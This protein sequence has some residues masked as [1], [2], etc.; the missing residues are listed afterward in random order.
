MAANDERYMQSDAMILERVAQ[1]RRN[2][3]LAPDPAS[4]QIWLNRI[5]SGGVERFDDARNAI[6]QRAQQDLIPELMHPGDLDFVGS[7]ESILER[8]AAIRENRGLDPDPASDQVWLDRILAHGAIRFDEARRRMDEKRL[9]HADEIEEEAGGEG[10][11]GPSGDRATATALINNM[12]E[13]YDLSFSESQ[14]QSWVE[15]ISDDPQNMMGL[16]EEEIRQ[17]PEFAQRFPGMDARL[18]AGYNAI[19]VE[20]YL[21]LEDSYRQVLRR[22]G[23]PSDFYTSRE[24]MAEFI[25]HDVSAQELEHR[26]VEGLIAAEQ[27]PA[28]VRDALQNF[29]GIQNSTSAL[30]AYFLDPE[31][32][33]PAIEREFESAQIQGAAVRTGFQGIGQQRAE[34]LQALGV[35]PMEAQQGFTQLTQQREIMAGG[36][37]EVG[38]DAISRD[39]QMD[40]IFRGDAFAQDRIR[41]Q[42]ERR[43][44][45]FAGEDAGAIQTQ[46][47][48][49]GLRA[50]GT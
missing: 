47:G 37:G 26:V 25:A 8:L 6:S 49:S 40:A 14:I 18:N 12:L 13:Q 21:S 46:T 4:D 42:Q 36:P 10:A 45:A 17:S 34:D 32:G 50:T 20:E 16:V 31:K 43:M 11:G 3:G 2:R 19:S 22:S 5:R 7:D 27:A 48:L 41:R 29:Y 30:A 33:L 23:M 44:S 24:D 39:A 38:A 9:R 1:I 15:R 28:E 35:D